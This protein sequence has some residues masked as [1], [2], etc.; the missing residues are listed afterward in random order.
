MQDQNHF[1]IL[2]ITYDETGAKNARKFKGK[3]RKM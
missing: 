3:Y 2:N 1:K